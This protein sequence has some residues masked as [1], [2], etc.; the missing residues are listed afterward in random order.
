MTRYRPR[1]HHH[2]YKA[3]GLRVASS[4]P[5]ATEDPPCRDTDARRA[6]WNPVCVGILTFS[7]SR[8]FGDG[9]RHFEPLS[10]TTPKLALSLLIAT[11]HQWVDV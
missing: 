6:Q 5:G 10:R 3:R 4:S 8:A 11:P 2:N 7:Y 1:V 9:P